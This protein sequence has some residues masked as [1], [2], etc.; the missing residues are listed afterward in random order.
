MVFLL[1]SVPDEV[2]PEEQPNG[3]ASKAE[4][5]DADDDDDVGGGGASANKK[6]STFFRFP[7]FCEL[8][9]LQS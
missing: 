4:A 6:K 5:I 9:T 1:R 2:K 8:W 7:G 3:G